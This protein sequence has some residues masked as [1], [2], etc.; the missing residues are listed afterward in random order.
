MTPDS[1][2]R[3]RATSIIKNRYFE[4][5][6]L[7][8]IGLSSVFLILDNPL[9]DPNSGLVTFLAYSD[10]VLTSFFLMESLLKIISFGLIA[11]G[12]QS[13]LR[14]GWN[15]MDALVVVLSLISIAFTSNKL[16][17]VKILRLLRVL[18]PLRVISRNKGLKI[19][20]QA[21]FMAIP[22][23]INVVI[24]SL[25]FFLIFGIIGV[26]YFKGAFFSC[27]F[28]IS[29]GD[30]WQPGGWIEGEIVTKFDCINWGGTW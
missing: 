4:S 18:R 16:K 8:L 22:S 15:I 19:G 17:I 23:L 13:Y 21:L 6:I 9:N 10:I 26:N 11:N 28:D 7:L 25:L 24:V 30:A 14:T 20:I 12:D 27:Y 3:T 29:Y 1:F 5:F 2:F